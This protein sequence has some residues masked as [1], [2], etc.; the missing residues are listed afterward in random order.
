MKRTKRT[1]FKVEK[2]ELLFLF[3][4]NKLEGFSP[5]EMFK[6]SHVGGLNVQK[7]MHKENSVQKLCGVC[8]HLIFK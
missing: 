1:E 2:I 8:A 6:S 5:I 7:G 4:Q 3:W